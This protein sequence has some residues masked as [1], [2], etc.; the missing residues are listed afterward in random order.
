MLI[1]AANVAMKG[2]HRTARSSSRRPPRS[3]ELSTRMPKP[4]LSAGSK[5]A[6]GPASSS[7]TR[8]G[9][10]A[11]LVLIVVAFIG[12]RH[13]PLC[14]RARRFTTPTD[15]VA[16]ARSNVAPE[17]LRAL[18]RTVLFVQAK[19]VRSM[20][21]VERTV[22]AAPDPP[23]RE[24]VTVTSVSEVAPLDSDGRS[25]DTST[26]SSRIPTGAEGQAALQAPPHEVG[27]ALDAFEV[28][29]TA[30]DGSDYL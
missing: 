2:A 1:G 15:S 21:R 27:A 25:Q 22:T 28:L 18:T 16:A 10:A 7:S 30:P 26:A 4:W 3:S 5:S 23:R 19:A 14:Y 9:A 8:Q 6:G 20:Y 13:S 24:P 11:R 17:M 29:V 12:V